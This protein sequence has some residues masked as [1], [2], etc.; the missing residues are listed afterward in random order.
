[1]GEML[2]PFAKSSGKLLIE[3]SPTL[4][5]VNLSANQRTHWLRLNPSISRLAEALAA[6][7][8]AEGRQ[9]IL[10]AYSVDTFGAAFN[11]RLVRAIVSSQRVAFS[12]AVQLDDPHGASAIVT[13]LM[14]A[15]TQR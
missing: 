14:A 3:P 6:K 5:N 1:M 15:G 13:A 7:L 11:D 2:A 4:T 10:I 8:I 12:T 9:K